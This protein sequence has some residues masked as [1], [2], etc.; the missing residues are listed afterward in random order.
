M[1]TRYI[2]FKKISE[3]FGV[4]LS[5]VYYWAHKPGYFKATKV[6]GRYFVKRK[7]FNEFLERGGDA[8]VRSQDKVTSENSIN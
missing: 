6:G 3:Y 1:A 8:L 4:S 7:D 5:L 2:S